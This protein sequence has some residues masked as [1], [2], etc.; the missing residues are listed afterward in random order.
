MSK[1]GAG[2]L[3]VWA[4]VANGVGGIFAVLGL[5]VQLAHGG[6]PVAFAI[7]G[8]VALL[9]AYS[10]AKLS[11]TY[12][13]R[14][15]TVTFL[16]RAFGAGLFTDSLNV[17]LWLSYVVMLS[18]YALAFGSYGATVLPES[19]HA[20]GKHVL[21]L[22]VTGGSF[23]QRLMLLNLFLVAFN[24]LPAFPMD[25][26]RVS[27]ALLAMRLGRRRAT[28]IA[29]NVGQGMAILFGIVGFFYNP[30]L[31]YERQSL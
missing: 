20:T 11:V 12:P 28:A 18:L 21:V 19:W 2:K 9:T 31:I 13:S 26:G 15:G 3:G 16:D 24:L 4:V 22:S 7:A 5:A 29:A 14:G 6:T 1:A 30:F 17:L 25:G 8:A 23:W 27:L 10:S